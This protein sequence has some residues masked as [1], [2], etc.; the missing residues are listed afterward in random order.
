MSELRP[1]RLDVPGARIGYDV[2]GDGP[3]LML[4]GSP[5]DSNGFRPLAGELIADFTVI[6]YDPRGI[7]RSVLEDPD[8]GAPHEV[9]AEDVY[10]VLETIGLGPAAIFGSSGGAVTALALGTAHPDVIG[11][12]VA[13]EPPVIAM[14]PDPDGARAGREKI[15][16]AYRSGGVGAGMAAFLEWTGMAAPRFEDAPQPSPEEAAAWQQASEFLLRHLVVTT[17]EYQPALDQLRALGERLTIGVG[18]ASGDQLPRRT[19]EA[20]AQR[21]G[22]RPVEFP[23]GHGGFL[24]DPPRFATRLRPLVGGPAGH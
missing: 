7:G 10:R 18:S 12:V 8:S 17:T 15:L 2:G 20:L 21:L 9:Q 1:Y 6:T 22:L 5:M 23:G 24:E 4:L 11:P 3:P 16:A 19:G 13:H 14:L